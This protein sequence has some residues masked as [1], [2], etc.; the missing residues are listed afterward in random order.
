MPAQ[1]AASFVPPPVYASLIRR[2]HV[3]IVGPRGSGKTTL[4]KMLQQPALEAWKHPRAEDFRSRIDYTGIFVAT[5]ISWGVQLQLLRDRRLPDLAR[6]VLA[7]AAFSTHVL[8]AFIQALLFRVGRGGGSA[9][10]EVSWRRA[11][12]SPSAEVS[13]VCAIARAWHLRPEVSTLESLRTSLTL[14]LSEIASLAAREALLPS[15]QVGE[16]LYDLVWLHLPFLQS[17]VLAIEL[18]DEAAQQ[19]GSRWALCF[20]ELE[21]APVEIR[22]LLLAALRSTDE[23]LIFK[24]ALSP[25]SASLNEFRHALSA[26]PS[27]DYEELSLWEFQRHEIHS[28][29][30]GLWSGILRERGFPDIAPEEALGHSLVSTQPDSWADEGTAYGPKSELVARFVR[31][32]SNDRSFRRYLLDN[33]IH[34]GRISL[35]SSNERASSVR[36][37]APLVALR[38]FYRQPDTNPEPKRL[39]TRRTRKKPTVLSGSESVFAITEGNPR[40]FLG[41]MNSLL[42]GWAPGDSISRTKQA[43]AILSASVRFRAMLK[44]L[45]LTKP[46][47]VLGPTNDLL[48]TLDQIG[49]YF[50]REVVTADFRPD[51]PLS[52]D[53]G[54][55][56][57]EDDRCGLEEA[58]NAGALVMINDHGLPAAVGSL[59][60]RRFRLSY[61]LAPYYGLPLRLGPVRG[62]GLILGRVEGSK[63]TSSR[64]I[65]LS[66]NQGEKDGSR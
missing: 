36:K 60:G 26:S 23:R 35:L 46:A 39:R 20:D 37:V 14:R 38:E 8:R 62:L 21:L 30:L 53:I 32:A 16:R 10:G 11:K 9:E 59:L 33:N 55:K 43:D 13:L 66:W 34:P 18:F 22:A 41:I 47:P 24:L 2:N 27:Q 28:L 25:Y 57:F 12:L 65:E 50:H 49:S 52:F 61:L 63:T 51:P 31:L 6:G 56:F 1:V 29:C 15:P 3:T 40:W 44:T 48:L 17:L 54:E 45:Q 64:Q 19:Q 4:L 7:C 58:L 5:D 42:E